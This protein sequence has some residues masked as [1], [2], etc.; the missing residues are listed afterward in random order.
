VLEEANIP[1]SAPPELGLSTADPDV[2]TLKMT[3]PYTPVPSPGAVDEYRCFVLNSATTVDKLMTSYQV[4]PGR[5][6]MV[7]HIVLYTVNNATDEAT[8]DNLDNQDS[9]P[10]YSCFGGPGVATAA[11]AIIWAPGQ[12]VERLPLGTGIPLTANRKSVIQIHY[13]TASVSGVADQTKI[14]MKTT[15]GASTASAQWLFVGSAWGATMA[16]GVRSINRSFP[17]NLPADGSMYGFFPHMHR[18][19]KPLKVES[20]TQCLGFAERW[21]FAWQLNYFLT[22]PIALSAGDTLTATCNYDTSRATRD[23]KFGENSEDEMC[24]GFIYFVTKNRLAGIAN[25]IPWS[26]KLLDSTVPEKLKFSVTTDGPNINRMGAVFIS[27]QYLGKWHF[28][29]P[30]QPPS[31]RWVAVADPTM[32]VALPEAVVS[33]A[34]ASLEFVMT[35]VNSAAHGAQ[36]Y[37]GAGYGASASDRKNDL[38][39][40]QRYTPIYTVP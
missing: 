24:F 31:Q 30:T 39:N 21:D 6:E 3:T 14:L 9:K 17:F 35:E 34:P 27:A 28:W 38:L 20:T 4:I 19:G 25:T 23:V 18:F 15:T 7:H 1:L 10:G 12:G 40:F 33:L 29:D 36:I 22:S 2:L 37:V 8:L 16:K 5:K 32:A 26:A 11:P 13:N